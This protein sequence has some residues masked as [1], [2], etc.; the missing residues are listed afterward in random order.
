[1]GVA[2]NMDIAPRHE[3][4]RAQRIDALAAPDTVA[5]LPPENSASRGGSAI[6]TG[7]CGSRKSTGQ[8]MLQDPLGW[9]PT[10]GECVP[11]AW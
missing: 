5:G 7:R 2:E 3:E 8:R 9:M 4:G 11:P 1:M 6:S 10:G